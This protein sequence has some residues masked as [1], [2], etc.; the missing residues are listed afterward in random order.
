MLTYVVLG[1]EIK[2]KIVIYLHHCLSTFSCTYVYVIHRRAKFSVEYRLVCFLEFVTSSYPQTAPGIPRE[3]GEDGRTSA[4]SRAFSFE[5]FL[6]LHFPANQPSF[7]FSVDVSTSLRPSDVRLRSFAMGF[8]V[9]RA[10]HANLVFWIL[11]AGATLMQHRFI[12]FCRMC[13]Y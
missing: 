6:S 4:S 1:F 13:L 9:A 3:M 2:N 7:Y 8:L 11:L 12:H 10:L 5:F